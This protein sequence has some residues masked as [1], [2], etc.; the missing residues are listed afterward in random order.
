[1]LDQHAEM[2]EAIDKY[3]SD[4]SEA[5]ILKHKLRFDHSQEVQGLVAEHNQEQNN[6][7]TR[8]ERLVAGIDVEQVNAAVLKHE[9]MD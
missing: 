3:K 9:V 1:M 6:Q 4:L 8:F 5:N 2:Q 7:Q